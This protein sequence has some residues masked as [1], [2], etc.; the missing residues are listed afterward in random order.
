MR[1]FIVLGMA[2]ALA[3][4][5]EPAGVG[6]GLIDQEGVD[7]DAI[8]VAAASVDTLG[9]S[10]TAIG[11][12]DANADLFQSRVL[13]GRVQDDLFGDAAPVAYLDAVQPSIDSD[14]EPSDVTAVWLELRR[15]YVYGDTTATLPIALSEI[16]GSW[17]AD[18]SYPA[19]TLFGSGAPLVT[20]QAAPTDTLVRWTLPQSWVTA[21]A[22]TLL[23]DSF[24]SDFE[25]VALRVPEGAGPSPGAVVGFST[26]ASQGSGF[27]VVAGGDTLFFALAEVFTSAQREAPVVAPPGLLPS[28][29]FS[30][31]GVRL[32]FDLTGIETAPLA[33]A[34]LTLPL[35]RSTLSSGTFVRPVATQSSVFGV[36]DD[37]AAD[38]LG[39][40]IAGDGDAR[41]TAS[42]ALTRRLQAVVVGTA[43]PYDRIEVRT[44][45]S[46]VSTRPISLDVLPVA[47]RPGETG[48]RLVLTVV[49][50]QSSGGPDG[51]P[52]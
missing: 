48:A 23:G 25:G 20:V 6:L 26:L 18:A 19:D 29:A 2:L 31:A 44:G 35:D 33:R 38:Y 27:R 51:D 15:T 42:A 16:E 37:G 30:M 49:G 39:E 7:P 10:A 52:S 46:A 24:G 5:Q 47:L 41:V 9:Q 14:L 8:T 43:E 21:N 4:C 28:R 3:A 17:Q 11:F 34:L 40:L 13:V 45:T 36:R 22:A 32:A 1:P 12:A 50:G